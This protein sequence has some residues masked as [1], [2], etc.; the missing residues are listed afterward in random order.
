MTT[1]EAL[2]PLAFVG[3]LVWLVIEIAWRDPSC[4]GA[5]AR[6]SE[7]FARSAPPPRVPPEPGRLEHAGSAPAAAE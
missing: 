7:A 1:L 5:M 2:A 6:D 4:F 3:L